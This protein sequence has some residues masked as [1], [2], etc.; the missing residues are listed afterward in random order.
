MFPALRS[1]LCKHRETVQVVALGRRFKSTSCMEQWIRPMNVLSI[2]SHVVFGH[3][4]NSAATFPMRRS[5]V[6]VWPL[7]TVQFSNHTQYGKF[8]G[9]PTSPALLGSIVDGID[10]I[11]SLEV[12][13][14]VVSGYLG[15]VEQGAQIL[16]TVAKI[17]RANPNAIY[18]CDPVM[19]HPDKGC[20]VPAG[21]EEFF[22]SE[23]AAASDIICPN[24]LELEILS[25]KPVQSFEDA[26]RAVSDLLKSGPRIVLVKH[27]GR[28]AAKEVGRDVFEMIAGDHHG[29]LW[30]IERPMLHFDKEPVGVGDL[31]TGLFLTQ[32]LKGAS[33]HAALEHTTAAVFE[34]MLE[35]YN[36]GE[37]EMQLVAAQDRIVAPRQLFS[38]QRIS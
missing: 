26:I 35:T 34:V 10:A 15:S 19:G 4:G 12:C 28:R 9:E 33:V 24:A 7:N 6:N 25:G 16:A 31:T 22:K 29:N 14:A 3:A 32:I 27:L 1:V 2:Q 11:G 13:D 37:Y 8:S 20:I 23:A 17:K 38:A 21:V 30:H 5:G 18:C 36:S